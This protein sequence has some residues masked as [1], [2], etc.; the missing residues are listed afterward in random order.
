MCRKL[1]LIDIDPS[2]IPI[3][4]LPLQTTLT[5]KPCP[6]PVATSY[7]QSLCCAEGHV[8][9]PESIARLYESAY[10]L[11]SIDFPDMPTNLMTASLPTPD[12]RR[13]IHCLQLWG[14]I[15]NHT[16]RPESFRGLYRRQDSFEDLDWDL[17]IRTTPSK[18]ES[19]PEP[20]EQTRALHRSEL[21]HADLMS[22]ADSHLT[23]SP[24]DTPDVSIPTPPQDYRRLIVYGL[25]RHLY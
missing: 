6:P 14:P 13:A 9:E 24:L 1:T 19:C 3:D 8:L 23:R 10:D 11:N 20:Q 17:R 16:P 22:F 12:L 7:L 18:D 2:L 25:P 4:D 15:K 5:F 21:Y